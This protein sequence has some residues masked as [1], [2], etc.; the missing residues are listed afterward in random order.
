MKEESTTFNFETAMV[1][2]TTIVEQMEKG[3][4]SLE[5]SLIQFEQGISLI[6]Q[7][8]QALSVAEQKVNLLVGQDKLQPFD[9][10]E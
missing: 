1:E 5:Q 8:Q 9:I 10:P 4:L 6:R 7:C 2:L 3:Q